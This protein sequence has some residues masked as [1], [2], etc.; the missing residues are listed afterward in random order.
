MLKEFKMKI[1]LWIQGW[2]GQLNSWAW[3]KWDKLHREDWV[4]GYKKWKKDEQ[5]LY[6]DL[7]GFRSN[8]ST[9]AL[10]AGGGAVKLSKALIEKKWKQAQT[11]PEGKLI[12]ETGLT[13]E[14]WMK[15]NDYNV[16]EIKD[17]DDL[18]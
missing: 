18:E 10:Y 2:S 11:G 8:R 9:V 3:T 14:E 4:K 12:R 16:Y 7:Y 15:Q 13:K 6:N 1:L 5:N 17:P